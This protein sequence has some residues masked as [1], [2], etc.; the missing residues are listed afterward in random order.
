MGGT[1]RPRTVPKGLR[2]R[3]FWRW[4]PF[5]LGF[6]P[7]GKANQHL[8][9]C[10]GPIGCLWPHQNGRNSYSGAMESQPVSPRAHDGRVLSADRNAATGAGQ[11]S[12]TARAG[13]TDTPGATGTTGTTGTTDDAEWLLFDHADGF[14]S[15]NDTDT[16]AEVLAVWRIQRRIALSY[17]A[18]FLMA[19]LCV[20]LAIHMLPW[21]TN[22]A[23]FAGFSPGFVLAAFGLY[24]FFLVVGWAA[25]SLANAVEHRMMGATSVEVGAVGHDR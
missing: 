6:G 10:L 9:H 17:M 20:G 21:A 23:V 16:P 15:F 22:T 8:A 25:A 19:T 11:T 2:A 12:E 14:A 13:T 4:E 18:V 7:F 24:A 3:G 5:G 1:Q